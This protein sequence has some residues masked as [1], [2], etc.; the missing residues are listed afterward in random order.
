MQGMRQNQQCQCMNVIFFGVVECP[1]GVQIPFD[2]DEKCSLYGT[3]SKRFQEMLHGR[4]HVL[5]PLGEVSMPRDVQGNPLFADLSQMEVLR[6]LERSYNMKTGLV[7]RRADNRSS[8]SI[9]E[10]FYNIRLKVRPL[11]K[12]FKL[13][14]ARLG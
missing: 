12:M 1:M 6:V 5:K 13:M 11:H 10:V 7:R 2:V 14:D 8:A 9:L 3:I 4:L